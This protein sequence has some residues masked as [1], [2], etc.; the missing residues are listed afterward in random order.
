MCLRYKLSIELLQT[1]NMTDA[2]FVAEASTERACM[3]LP[4]DGPL[5]GDM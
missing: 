2:E 5:L 1:H 4:E 3:W